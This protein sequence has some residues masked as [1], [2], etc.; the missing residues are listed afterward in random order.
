M[1]MDLDASPDVALRRAAVAF[2]AAAGPLL[3]LV[4]VAGCLAVLLQSGFLLRTSALMPDLGRLSPQRG[5]KRLFSMDNAMEALKAIAKLGVLA[6]AAWSALLAAWPQTQHA[7]L[8]MPATLVD[9][10][11]RDLTHLLLLVLACQAGIALLDAGWS[12]WR[13]AQRMR[14]SREDLKQEQ[15]ES[16]GDPRIKARLR[17][18]RLARARRRMIAAVGRATVV[19]TNPT[20]YA[21]ALSYERGAQSAPRVVAKGV[22]DVAARIR[23]A[24]QKA[25]V[26][27]MPNPPLARALYTVPLDA[28]VPVEHFK[29]VAEIIAYVWRL[30]GMAGRR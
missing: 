29:A 4:L 7:L 15:K 24:A 21:I 3:G 6:W 23:E 1:L 27:Q 26:P 12:R 11:G 8:W 19:I 25:G 18:L 5:L 28:E 22:D 10:I 20:H 16:D 17:Q 30:K 2:M 9:R 14:M 13:F